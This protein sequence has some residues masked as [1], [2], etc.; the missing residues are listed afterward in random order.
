[1]K[2][3]VC[4]KIFFSRLWAHMDFGREILSQ[5]GDGKNLEFVKSSLFFKETICLIC[6]GILVLPLWS[7][8]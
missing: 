7:R 8:F 3:I 4:A 5:P 6:S 2:F 1:M